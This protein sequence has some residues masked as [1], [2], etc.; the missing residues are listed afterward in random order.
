MTNV[1][2]SHLLHT[3]FAPASRQESVEL[4]LAAAAIARV[5]LLWEVLNAIPCM[6][7]VLNHQRQIVAAND[8]ALQTLQ[9]T[10][11]DLIGKRPGEAVACIRAHEGP[12]GCGTSR[13]CMTCG[14]VQAIL[15]SQQQNCPVTRECRILTEGASGIVPL[16]LRVNARPITVEGI[17]LIV[18]T[19][20]DISH[21]KRLAVLQRVFFHDVLNTVSCISGYVYMLRNRPESVEEVCDELVQL[22]GLLTEE[23]RA[24]QDLMTAEAGDLRVQMEPVSTRPLLESLRQKYLQ[25]AVAAERTIALRNVWEG[26]VTTDRRLLM[27]VV[28]NMLKNALEATAP[29][30]TVSLDCIDRGSA[31]TFAVHNVE[32][33]P[34]AVQL[35]I[36]LRSFSTKGETGRG[37][38]TYSMKLLGERYLGGVVDFSS[39]PLEG[40]TFTLT[41]PKQR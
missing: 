39:H 8:A 19:I 27:R 35:Q 41:L 31:V 28:G 17:P 24:Q 15:G 11:P 12:G 2:D 10:V 25:N 37:V 1:N 33:M 29:G 40:T 6:V 14:A 7:L 4:S 36:F 30:C 34:E 21:A 26:N 23:I 20:E 9:T 22:S 3:H 16:D 32:A 18:L 38:G 13:H 5:P